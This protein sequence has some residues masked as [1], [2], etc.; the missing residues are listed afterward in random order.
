[1]PVMGWDVRGLEDPDAGEESGQQDR[2]TA[3]KASSNTATDGGNAAVITAWSSILTVKHVQN[4][5]LTLSHLSP[6]AE[7]TAA[8]AV[9][10]YHRLPDT[11]LD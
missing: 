10:K 7:V 3:T 5:W 2:Q 1:M 6:W 4:P 9:Q 11:G 8:S